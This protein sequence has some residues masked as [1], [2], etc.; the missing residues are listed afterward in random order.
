M[1]EQFLRGS[2]RSRSTTAFYRV[3]HKIRCTSEH[4]LPQSRKRFYLVALRADTLRHAFVWPSKVD[5]LPLRSVLCSSPT[6]ASPARRPGIATSLAASN[7]DRACRGLEAKGVDIART[8][9]I[10]DCDASLQWCGRPREVC[11]C[12]T[13]SRRQGYWHLGWGMRLPAAAAM[14]LQGLPS[15]A[16]IWPTK[17]GDIRALAGNSMSLCVLEPV[18]RS[19]LIACGL[20]PLNTPD[21]WSDGSAQAALAQDA[22][23]GGVP[24]DVL[25]SLP[26]HVRAHL[27]P[28]YCL[29]LPSVTCESVPSTVA[30]SASWGLLQRPYPLTTTPLAL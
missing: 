8:N 12:L 9:F 23:P 5:M 3:F 11:P 17:Y 26:Y 29:A 1:V 22:W 10:S 7:V 19:G 28:D 20:C 16:A 13:R 6:D 18:L 24:G 14:R 21:R 2:S 25:D 4:G 27:D 30:N 15:T